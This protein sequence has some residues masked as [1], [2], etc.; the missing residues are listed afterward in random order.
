MNSEE[1]IPRHTELHRSQQK[2]ELQGVEV[3]VVVRKILVIFYHANV[4]E[5]GLFNVY[6]EKQEPEGDGEE[7][8]HSLKSNIKN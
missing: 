2:G 6:R 8:Q 7:G 1:H 4:E 5:I 3:K